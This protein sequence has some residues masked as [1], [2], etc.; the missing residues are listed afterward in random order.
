MV[1]R[2]QSAGEEGGVCLNEFSSMIS[3]SRDVWRLLSEMGVGIS[4]WCDVGIVWQ[5]M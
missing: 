2:A 1:P 3:V 4:R 5:D